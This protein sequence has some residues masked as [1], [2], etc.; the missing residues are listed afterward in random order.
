MSA[1]GLNGHARESF[2]GPLSVL[3]LTSIISLRNG[4]SRLTD[5]VFTQKLI[6]YRVAAAGAKRPFRS[7]RVTS[8]FGGSADVAGGR[9]GRRERAGAAIQAT[10]PCRRY[11]NLYPWLEDAVAVQWTAR[12]VVLPRRGLHIEQRTY[13]IDT[14]TGFSELS[15][16]LSSP[17]NFTSY[18]TSETAT[19][20]EHDAITCIF[21]PSLCSDLT[22]HF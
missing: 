13:D 1:C 19:P 4:V 8:A 12:L 18:A 16:I 3:E 10:T 6:S 20:F 21:D 15:V 5:K 2:R 11:R 7:V 14:G 22:A 17:E 9:S